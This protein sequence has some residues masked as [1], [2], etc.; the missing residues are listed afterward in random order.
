MLSVFTRLLWLDRRWLPVF[1]CP[2]LR[3]SSHEQG[4]LDIAQLD[5]ADVLDRVGS[6]L[7]FG[8]V[9]EQSHDGSSSETTKSQSIW[10]GLS[11]S[12]ASVMSSTVSP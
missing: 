12:S 6:R 2:E 1:L 8:Y 7:C 4:E 3:L 11:G 9:L 10:S 5:H